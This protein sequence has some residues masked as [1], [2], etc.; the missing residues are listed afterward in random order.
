MSSSFNNRLSCIQKVNH[1]SNKHLSRVQKMNYH[2]IKACHVVISDERIF[3]V[4]LKWRYYRVIRL[5]RSYPYIPFFPCLAACVDDV[6]LKFFKRQG[7]SSFPKVKEEK[8]GFG[9][10]PDLSVRSLKTKKFESLV[11]V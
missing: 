6:T 11:C 8:K 3:R 7:S 1:M 4:K 10:S 2:S 9:S 5:N